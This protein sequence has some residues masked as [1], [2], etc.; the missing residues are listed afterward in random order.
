MRYQHR[1]V[2]ISLAKRSK[3]TA[4][5]N[6]CMYIRIY[7]PYSDRSGVLKVILSVRL[8]QSTSVLIS[9]VLVVHPVLFRER[10]MSNSNWT[11]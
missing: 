4:I 10:S 11:L 3:P 9:T 6:V 5:F 2:N 7:T 1:L 8:G